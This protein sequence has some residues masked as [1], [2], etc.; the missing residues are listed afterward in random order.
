M[1]GCIWGYKKTGSSCLSSSKSFASLA[2]P[3]C[4]TSPTCLCDLFWIWTGKESEAFKLTI[5]NGEKFPYLL[6]IHLHKPLRR[7]TKTSKQF[8]IGN[9]V[10]GETLN[11]CFLFSNVYSLL[12]EEEK[13]IHLLSD[14]NRFWRVPFIYIPNICKNHMP[15]LLLI[16]G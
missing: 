1:H 6:C 13:V 14:T 9:H 12:Q 5:C 10:P 11:F 2:W 15:D 16:F 7:A 8:S 3:L 4:P